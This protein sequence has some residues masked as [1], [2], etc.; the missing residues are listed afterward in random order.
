[1]SKLPPQTI[2][3][4]TELALI[5]LFRAR[6]AERVRRPRRFDF[7]LIADGMVFDSKLFVKDET[8]KIDLR[9]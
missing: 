3:D 1:M 7:T 5:T 8:P 9:S 4:Q 6:L 2:V